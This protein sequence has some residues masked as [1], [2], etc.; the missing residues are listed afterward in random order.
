ML[1]DYGTYMGAEAGSLV[2]VDPVTG[3]WTLMALPNLVYNSV[4]GTL[5]SNQLAQIQAANVAANTQAATNPATGQVNQPLLDQANT[6]S[7]GGVAGAANVTNLSTGSWL[8]NLADQL[9]GTYTGALGLPGTTPA[10]GTPVASSAG[11]GIDW[12]SILETVALIAGGGLA[13]YF[14]V[15]AL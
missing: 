8:A 11:G 15:K 2:G 1:N 3:N 13:I 6:E 14:I 10:L 9:Q 5:D 7:A 4:T 12:T